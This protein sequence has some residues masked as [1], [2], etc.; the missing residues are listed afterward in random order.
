MSELLKAVQ[1]IFGADIVK[2]VEG[3]ATVLGP[4]AI[5]LDQSSSLY[6]NRYKEMMLVI[7][8]VNGKSV[9]FKHS[10][11][12]WIQSLEVWRNGITTK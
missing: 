6:G 4:G 5:E 10:E 12:A 9:V 8:F 3:D 1:D 7:H 11:W 2:S